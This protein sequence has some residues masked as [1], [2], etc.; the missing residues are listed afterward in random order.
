MNRTIRILALTL[1][2]VTCTAIAAGAQMHKETVQQLRIYQIYDDTKPAFHDRFR[3]HA[4]R[5]M[6]RYGFRIVATWETQNDGRTEFAYLLDW[7]DEATMKAAWDG[8]M[9][10]EEWKDIKRRTRGDKPLVQVLSDRTLRPTAYSPRRI[11]EPS[12]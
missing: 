4:M 9:A 7:P 2:L 12:R 11:A 5:I 1:A 8:F 10:D 3:D 6:A